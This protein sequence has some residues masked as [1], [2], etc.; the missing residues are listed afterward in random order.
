[1]LLLAL[2]FGLAVYLLINIFIVWFAT[3][4]AGR[5]VGRFVAIGLFLVVFWDLIPVYAVH[6]Y[7]CKTSAGFTV[8]KTLDEWKRKNPGVWETL[9]RDPEKTELKIYLVKTERDDSFYRLPE[10]TELHAHYSRGNHTYTK[11]TR[12]DGTKASW[13]NQRFAGITSYEKFWHIV[14]KTDKSIVDQK[15]GEII[16]Q[17][18]DFSASAGRLYNANELKDYKIWFE[19]RSCEWDGRKVSRKK[20]SEFEHLIKYKKDIEL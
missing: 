19:A 7:Q 20:F 6:Y 1:M 8:H 12:S 17:Y 13:H 9:N 14:R 18:V 5:K 11:I 15:T 16:A 3:E 2:L 10:G 4:I